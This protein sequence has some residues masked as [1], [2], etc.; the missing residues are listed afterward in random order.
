MITLE[1]A[2]AGIGRTVIYDDGHGR[3]EAGVITSVSER[4]VFVRYGAAINSQAT[5]PGDLV[6]ETGS[7]RTAPPVALRPSRLTC[8]V[9][10]APGEFVYE[11][12]FAACAGD[13]VAVQRAVV[14][15]YGFDG[16]RPLSFAPIGAA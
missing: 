5:N 9:C 10:G 8:C 6:F 2:R 3:R 12:M 13:S 11:A 16:F 14:E 1:Q 15:R 7:T 4:F